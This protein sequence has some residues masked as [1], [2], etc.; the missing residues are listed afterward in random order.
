MPYAKSAPTAD[1]AHY[2]QDR[3][4]QWQREKQI[5]KDAARRRKMRAQSNAQRATAETER[6]Q[7]E[8]AERKCKK[9]E[10]VKYLRGKFRQDRKK[11]K[12]PREP[13]QYEVNEMRAEASKRRAVQAR[14]REAAR[15]TDQL[16]AATATARALARRNARRRADEETVARTA[17]VG[18]CPTTRSSCGD[19]AAPGFDGTQPWSA[20]ADAAAA[21]LQQ[22]IDRGK[23]AQEALSK[24]H[25]QHITSICDS[26]AS[27]MLFQAWR[28]EAAEAI[29]RGEKEAAA[30]GPRV[31][32]AERLD[33]APSEVWSKRLD[34]APST[35]FSSLDLS[36]NERQKAAL[37]PAQ[38]TGYG[39]IHAQKRGPGTP[40]KR[41][42]KRGEG[43][44]TPTTG[45]ARR[46][47]LKGR[48]PP[49]R[50]PSSGAP[51]T[52]SSRRRREKK[53]KPAS[54]KRWGAGGRLSAAERE[55]ELL[56]KRKTEFAARQRLKHQAKARK[57]AQRSQ[58]A[59][60]PTAATSVVPQKAAPMP[61]ERS[62][63]TAA[64]QK[65]LEL[66]KAPVP[67]PCERSPDLPVSRPRH[68]S[69]KAPVDTALISVE[70]RD[71][72]KSL[73]RLD[74]LIKARRGKKAAWRPPSPLGSLSPVHESPARRPSPRRRRGDARSP[75]DWR[76]CSPVSDASPP[77]RHHHR[78]AATDFEN[79]AARMGSKPRREAR[80]HL[81]DCPPLPDRTNQD[82]LV[83]QTSL[84]YL[85]E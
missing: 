16:E 33:H 85:L 36:L 24:R 76:R 48:T 69:R 80:R 59:S 9:L 1:A 15:R 39:A 42:A 4:L 79:A 35:L 64:M 23:Q 75:D 82:G 29:K 31:A 49:Q 11:E 26:P 84:A 72:A 43:L 17:P 27:T 71:V 50:T 22:R 7:N 78:D 60:A 40:P 68:K 77:R 53:P 19:L 58:R 13:T 62:P 67:M 81:P 21:R 74:G 30:P 63:D 51:T 66:Q 57:R 12:T 54:P 46:A 61:C 20:V 65:P 10:Y 3:A 56:R 37:P 44:D 34:H 73:R 6:A 55:K 2:E 38:P 83:V 41:T 52:A 45:Y 32:E 25:Q 5:R 70:E 8:Y 14:E 28:D 47:A 18:A